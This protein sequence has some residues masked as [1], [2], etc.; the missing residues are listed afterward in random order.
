[1]SRHPQQAA[2][3]ALMTR[4]KTSAIDFAVSGDHTKHYDR[5]TRNSHQQRV[6]SPTQKNPGAAPGGTTSDDD[7]ADGSDR[8]QSNGAEADNEDGDVGEPDVQAPS[9]VNFGSDKGQT[10]LNGDSKSLAGVQNKK[11]TEQ[12]FASAT[13]GSSS[14]SRPTED[15]VSDDED[16]N[17]VD[18]ISESGDEEPRVEH[19]EEKAIIDSEE[20]NNG[21]PRLLSPPNSL[22]DAFSITSADL[23]NIDFDVDPFLTDEPFFEEQ[24]GLLDPDECANDAEDYGS[25]NG[26]RFA[27][28]LADT[29]RRRVRFADPLMLPSEAG[30]PFFPNFNDRKTYPNYSGCNEPHKKAM[31]S[32]ENSQDCQ[33]SHPVTESEAVHHGSSQ[34]G[35]FGSEDHES[36]E[37]DD[38][39]SSVGSSSGYET[40]QG[41]TTD[42]EDVPASATTRPSA[43]LRDSSTSALNNRL[44]QQPLP[45]APTGR[46]PPGHRWGP[47][48]GSWVTDP[49]KPIAVVASSGKELIVFPAQ[50]PTSRGGKI[51]PTVASSGRPSAQPS[52]R[53]SQ[54]NLPAPFCP[55]ATDDSELEPSGMSSQETATPMFG[56]SPN[57]MMPGLGLGS[58]NLLSGHALGP[59]EAFFPFQS[60]GADGKMIL[61]GLDVDDED[62]DGDD[63]EDLLNIEDFID[64]GE[65]SED[66]D[67]EPGSATDSCQSP[68]VN[69]SDQATSKAASTASPSPTAPTHNFLDHFD[70][71]VVT[72]FRRNQYDRGANGFLPSSASSFRAAAAMKGNAFVGGNSV[73]S[74]LKKR[75][76]GDFAV[77]APPNPGFAKRRMVNPR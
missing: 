16:Y 37:D 51:F 45:K 19:V 18:L 63:G 76:V 65:D 52:P 64:F 20:D 56:A 41:E 13:H 46:L 61:D 59:P 60:I 57:L 17:G 12:D 10:G 71:G 38:G 24:M 40:D 11:H 32:I 70:K 1:M 21:H 30:A 4:G 50:R 8:S 66:S 14:P 53:L 58:G 43:L 68:I 33:H 74:T 44:A 31:K 29:P 28:P 73:P 39:E 55:S 27:S 15:I 23:A 5:P 3:S 75:K 2:K 22:S 72:A 48:L 6:S 54:R 47:T 36:V 42:E 77:P 35:V 34:D 26:Y 25:A 67:H 9:D 69:V 62:D 49:T 7:P